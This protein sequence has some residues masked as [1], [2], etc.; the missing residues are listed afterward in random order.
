MSEPKGGQALGGIPGWFWRL[1]VSVALL[2]GL[3][4]LGLNGGF[5]LLRS[6]Q[7]AD[8]AEWES[9]GQ[10]PEPPVEIVDAGLS[11]VYV[12][13]D[14]GSLFECDHIRAPYDDRC[15]NE[16]IEVGALDPGLE[17]RNTFAGEIPAPPG[18]VVQSLDLSW[19]RAE[20]AKHRRYALLEDGSVWLWDYNADANTGLLTLMGGPVC[21][22]GL[23]IVVVI[24]IWLAAGVRA[25]LRR[26]RST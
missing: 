14:G 13:V 24:L 17:Y 16:V 5:A 22:L 26:G 23:A 11:K 15:W 21:G 25:L 18:P 12:R 1:I 10:P 7:R 19:H 8:A 3:P 6:C 9:L 4:L 20:R 2:F